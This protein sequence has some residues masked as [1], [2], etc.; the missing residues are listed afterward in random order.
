MFGLMTIMEQIQYV[1]VHDLDAEKKK[2][3]DKLSTEYHAKIK[4]SLKNITS[5]IIHVKVHEKGGK[6]VKFSVHM[7]A[8]APTTIITSTKASDWD[9]ARTLHKAFKDLENQIEKRF[10]TYKTGV[11]SIAKVRMKT[12]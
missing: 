4:R 1:G 12:I 3:L 11:H 5:L 6:A 7:K 2:V 9:F 8:V 10:K